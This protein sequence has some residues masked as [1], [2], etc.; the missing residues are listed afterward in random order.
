MNKKNSPQG[1]GLVEVLLAIA[2]FSL[3]VT[4]LLS[5]LAYATQSINHR[6]N[7]NDAVRLASEGADAVRNTWRYDP[8]L[9]STGTFGVTKS[10]NILSITSTPDTIGIFTRTIDI[11]KG[12]TYAVFTITI[13]W[14]DSNGRDNELVVDGAS[15]NWQRT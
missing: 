15:T 1:F 3:V 6:N 8:S 14:Q 10:G 11:E 4:G 9:L 13:T 2:L 12:A 5:V 7:Y